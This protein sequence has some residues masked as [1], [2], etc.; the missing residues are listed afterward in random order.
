MVANFFSF[1]SDLLWKKCFWM[2]LPRAQEIVAF[3]KKM[4]I[5]LQS[6]KDVWRGI[7]VMK[8]KWTHCTFNLKGRTIREKMSV[9]ARGWKWWCRGMFCGFR[10]E[11]RLEVKCSWS[12]LP[13]RSWACLP[14]SER[15]PR[16]YCEK[17]NT[18]RKCTLERGNSRVGGVGWLGKMLLLAGPGGLLW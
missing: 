4:K 5:Q 10:R 16:R 8:C 3:F 1:F 15:A 2:D 18:R 17:E 12:L 11:H 7:N 6:N 14:L 9:T 13:M